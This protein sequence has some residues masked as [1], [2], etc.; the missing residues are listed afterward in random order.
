MALITLSE[1]RR[2]LS[3]GR[4]GGF[5]KTRQQRAER[6][7]L[8]ALV[9]SLLAAWFVWMSV[10]TAAGQVANPSQPKGSEEN[11]Q[12]ESSGSSEAAECSG[13]LASSK[14]KPLADGVATRIALASVS[15]PS[16]G[17][18][19][20]VKGEDDLYG[21][22]LN[23]LQGELNSHLDSR[24]PNLELAHR[25]KGQ[26][27]LRGWLGVLIQPLSPDIASAFGLKQQE[28]VIVTRIT[29][30][31]S[32]AG[33]AGIEAGD[34]INTVEDQSIRTVEDVTRKIA[35]VGPG[36]S[37][38][39]TIDHKGAAKTLTV[40]LAGV[41]TQGEVVA[42]PVS[43]QTIKTQIRNCFPALGRALKALADR[44]AEIAQAESA[45][46]GAAQE[47]GSPVTACRTALAS[48]FGGANPIVDNTV[49]P[50]LT[51]PEVQ[52]AAREVAESLRSEQVIG[53]DVANPPSSMARLSGLF[54]SNLRNRLSSLPI[55]R[56]GG[57]V[58]SWLENMTGQD[59]LSCFPD[60]LAAMQE[61]APRMQT[62]VQAAQRQ[63]EDQ[64]AE[65]KLPANILAT[66]Y[67]AYIDVKKCQ[68]AREGYADVYITDP[69]LEQAKAAVRKIEDA[70]KPKLGPGENPD[71]IWSQVTQTE[72]RH[73]DPA[74]DFQQGQRYMC[75]RR[76]A[77]VLQILHE[78]VPDSATIKKDF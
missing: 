9:Q 64:L 2:F 56:P 62:A 51:N 54:R 36:K 52:A 70:I 73:F 28:G 69:E 41:N 77:L 18:L 45:R 57:I 58:Q 55:G 26:L 48:H 33:R 68:D 76:L 38:S 75:Q 67:A 12:T 15:K 19:A 10:A 43:P 27:G 49:V 32:P 22:F 66:A 60:L 78:Q 40:T 39:I 29:D 37:V 34:L 25:L 74:H 61:F 44:R 1:S 50:Q 30:S 16:P 47:P 17:L 14:I 5:S 31:N 59:L 20:A 23:G 72:G 21:L 7:L 24:D 71:K 65:S 4:S 53:S 8:I 42:N 3:A 63:Q 35:S 11:A 13:P 6:N 46:S